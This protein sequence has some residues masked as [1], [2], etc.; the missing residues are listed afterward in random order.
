MQ[1][2][3]AL[4]VHNYMWVARTVR[5]RATRYGQPSKVFVIGLGCEL[6]QAH[7]LVYSEGLDLSE[8][9]GNLGNIAT[10]TGEGCRVREH[11]N[12]PER[13]FP[14]LGRALDL[15]AHRSTISPYLVK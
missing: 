11:E 15:D 10:S 8:D 1:I 9:L 14:A 12:C 3:D 13:M 6:C 4:E 5:R 7:R 2:G